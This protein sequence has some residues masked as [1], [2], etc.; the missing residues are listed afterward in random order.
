[1]FAPAASVQRPSNG[2]RHAQ[3]NGTSKH[4]T[5]SPEPLKTCEGAAND[6]WICQPDL[7]RAF[8]LHLSSGHQVG[9]PARASKPGAPVG[10]PACRLDSLLGRPLG[11]QPPVCGLQR[12][13]PNSVVLAPDCQ[14]WASGVAS[15]RPPPLW[16]R[17]KLFGAR[18]GEIEKGR[19]AARASKRAACARCTHS[20]HQF[21]SL[22]PSSLANFETSVWLWAQ[23]ADRRT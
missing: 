14:W 10:R 22:C 5:G 13:A 1:M 4:A 21:S 17:L 2:A 8:L 20:G 9:Q 11:V 12:V 18:D 6:K 16:P 19:E 3:I 7:A 15:G 23:M